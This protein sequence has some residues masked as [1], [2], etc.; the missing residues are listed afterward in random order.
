MN[1]HFYFS[2][3]LTLLVSGSAQAVELLTDGG[4]ELGGSIP[5]WELRES[6]YD[7]GSGMRRDFGT[8]NS[9]ELQ[10]FGPQ[11]GV[12]ALYLRGFE[13][14]Q[15]PGPDTQTNAS[16][17]QEV[18]VTGGNSY[19]LTGW[20][21][22]E[23]FY[24]GGQDPLSS[25]GPLGAITSPTTNSFTVSYLDGSGAIVGTP[26]E[27]DL[28]ADR[29]LRSGGA[30]F[31]DWVEHTVATTAPATAVTARVVADAGRMVWNSGQP[32]ESAFYDSFSF[33][34][35]A[36]TETELILNGGLEEIPPTFDEAWV[37][38]EDPGG[39][40]G[41]P[42]ATI[43][44]LSGANRADSGGA[45]GAWLRSFEG[46]AVDPAGAII[47]QTVAGEAGGDYIFTAWSNFQQNYV[48]GLGSNSTT[49]T[50]IELAF[51]D[52]MGNEIGTPFTL[53]VKADR[54]SQ[55][56]GNAN[57]SEWYQHTLSATAPANTAEVRVSGSGQG[58]FTNPAGGQQ[59][60]FFDDFSL[61][62][63]VSGI[64]GDFDGDGD[65]DIV[66]F[67]TFGQN[68][69]LTNQPTNPPVDGDFDSDGDVDIVDFGTFGQ[70]FGT[71]TPGS[72]S[73]VPEPASAWLLGLAGILFLRWERQTRASRLTE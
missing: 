36:A 66:D 65:V 34:D 54:Q 4:F 41:T 9:A 38:T 22:F 20:S 27:F 73:A 10:G 44:V 47:A 72:S 14:G 57:D 70:N 49:T 37:V 7:V 25:G 8:V 58:M 53:D 42:G 55:S 3:A 52:D 28:I 69:G 26:T 15:T 64:A 31:N 23:F 62:L 12:R 48:G 51:L 1:R 43:S 67:G 61:D 39:N 17:I 71:G 50:E 21:R 6:I 40:F 2:V 29:V 46:S 56:G 59:S 13:G 60:A 5:N 11:D 32:N 30:N 45:V 16:L 35:D 68:F 18:P 63:L 33:V 24:S 19:T